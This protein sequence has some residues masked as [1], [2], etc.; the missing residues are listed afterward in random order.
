MKLNSRIAMASKPAFNAD[1]S[2]API[3]FS[4][5]LGGSL[6]AA[7]ESVSVGVDE[8]P[9]RLAIPFLKRR[10]K[11]PVLASIGSFNIAVSPIQLATEAAG[12]QVE[13]VIGTKGIDAKIDGKVDCKTDMVL[14]GD[15]AGKVGALSL[16]FVEEEPRPKPA[17]SRR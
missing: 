11:P 2:V 1:A 12:F 5:M 10:G 3:G 14:D 8:I 9:L 7:L 15:V 6:R 13:G 17:R 16:E 4:A